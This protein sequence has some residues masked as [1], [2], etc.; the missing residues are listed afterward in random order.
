M[1]GAERYI[2]VKAL[3]HPEGIVPGLA[4]ADQKHSHA[5]SEQFA[6][7]PPRLS[8]RPRVWLRVG[9]LV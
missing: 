7:A 6:G 1:G 3:E 4:A 9:R 2:C 5:L 8:R